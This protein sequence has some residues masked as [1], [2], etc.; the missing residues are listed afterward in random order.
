MKNMDVSFN[1]HRAYSIARKEVMHILRDP[2]TLALALG[3]PVMLVTF[4]G[5][6]IDFEVK[7]IKLA[8]SDRDNGPAARRFKEIF[9]ASGY[10]QPVGT[11]PA[12]PIACLLYTS[13]SPRDS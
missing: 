8:V 5:Y 13:P 9:S 1:F 3:L 6:A 2:F 7:D 4:F 11:G 12:G 10:F